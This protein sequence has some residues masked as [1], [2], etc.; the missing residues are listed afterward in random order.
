MTRELAEIQPNLVEFFDAD[1]VGGDD[2]FTVSSVYEVPALS[3]RLDCM[4]DDIP[5][6]LRNVI[7]LPTREDDVVMSHYQGCDVNAY[8]NL[9]RGG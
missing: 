4:D 2:I 1:H 9:P 7:D 5:R 8:T 3:F 6:K